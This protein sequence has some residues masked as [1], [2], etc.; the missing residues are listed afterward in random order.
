[1]Q[2]ARGT[3]GAASVFLLGCLTLTFLLAL[4][5]SPEGLEE[6]DPARQRFQDSLRRGILFAGLMVLFS[7]S[8]RMA[9]A[10]GASG[11]PDLW[12]RA[13]MAVGG[14][15]LV[16]TGNAIPKTLT[17]WSGLQG[18]AGRIQAFQRFAGWTWV[19][20]GLAM[21]IT[22]LALPVRLAGTLTLVLM[23][24]AMLLIAAQA[25]RLRRARQRTA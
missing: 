15:F 17:P 25:I 4:R 11:D 23:P 3:A 19:L 13:T 9:T 7:M 18:D 2:P 21:A 5:R 22:W 16:F 24:S 6:V 12:R 20:A 1:L 10:L 8:G 14:S